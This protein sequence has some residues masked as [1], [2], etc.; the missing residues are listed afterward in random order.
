M[1]ITNNE[2][3]GE[4]GVVIVA[5]NSS[6]HLPG[7][8]ESLK[9][10]NKLISSVNII[11]NNSPE[12]LRTT[13]IIGRIQQTHPE[14]H[15]RYVQNKKNTGFGAACNQGA[16]KI[17]SKYILFLNPDT[18][19]K[20]KA[21]QIL[22]EH[23]K[24]RNCDIIGG[25]CIKN[26]TSIHR[27]AVRHPDLVVGL[28]EFSN[29]GKILN[30]KSGQS[31]FYYEDIQIEK[32]RDDIHVDAVSGAYLLIKR[33]SLNKL[34]G[35]DENFFMYLEDVDLGHRAN[36]A[37]MKVCYCPHSE[38][39][40]EGGASSKNKYRITHKAWF[41]SRKMYY[42]KHYGYGVNAIIQPLFTLEEILLKVRSH[43]M[44]ERTK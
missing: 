29:L 22:L 3:R 25:K 30:T 37:G 43:V 41:D 12:K 32:A 24:M 8:F 39:W 2:T 34:T 42:K 7:L 33:E 13:K 35:F 1:S 9:S 5:Y 31:R 11:E 19:L 21:L 4:I 16:K 20:E 40:H 27:T 18:R 23:S 6:K 38:I 10:A 28:F 44:R 14:L 36:L 26:K 17:R 15:I